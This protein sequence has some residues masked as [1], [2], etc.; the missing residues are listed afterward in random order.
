MPPCMATPFYTSQL[1][2]R[3]ENDLP[4]RRTPYCTQHLVPLEQVPR[5]DPVGNVGEVLA[6]AVGHDHAAARLEAP[7]VARDL[8]AE[9]LGRVERGHVAVVGQQLLGV[10]GEAVAATSTA[11]AEAAAATILRKRLSVQLLFERLHETS[12][13][14][15]K[16]LMGFR[17]PSGIVVLRGAQNRACV[18]RDLKKSA[19]IGVGVPAVDMQF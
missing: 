17:L 15:E 10:L 4:K 3:L 18:V 5:V 13:V 2:T 11:E 14:A 6:P 7:Q 19:G 9:E 1:K 12:A 16:P 8:G